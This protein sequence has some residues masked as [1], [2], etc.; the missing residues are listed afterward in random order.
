MPSP[1]DEQFE[2]Y[3]K[4]FRPLDPEALPTKVPERATR[5]SFIFAVWA[6]AAAWVLV[7]AL[8]PHFPVKA[9]HSGDGADKATTDGKVT[10]QEP[11]TLRR[12]NALLA[13]SPSVKNALDGLAFHSQPTPLR[14]G[15]LSALNV[16]SEEKN[17]L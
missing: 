16:L 5:R 6:G 13:E 14:N 9:P 11:L 1:D 15:A 2:H 3:L 7:V 4:R 8:S 17:K 12:A 10:T